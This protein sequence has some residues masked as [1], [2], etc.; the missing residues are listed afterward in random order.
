MLL[1]VLGRSGVRASKLEEE[2][3]EAL[4]GKALGRD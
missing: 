2:E 1:V 4:I 3:V